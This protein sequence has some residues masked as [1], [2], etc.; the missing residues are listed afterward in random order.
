MKKLI[1]ILTTLAVLAFN[2]EVMAVW[3]NIDDGQ[4]HTIN[5]STYQEDVVF[6][7]YYNSNDPGTH[8]NLVSGGHVNLLHACDKSTISMTGGTIGHNLTANDNASITMS[9]GSVKVDL[10]ASDYSHIALTG[11]SVED[12]LYARYNSNITV[13][14]G[15]IRNAIYVGENASITMSGGLADRK[16]IVKDSGKV[17]LDGSDFSITDSDG[18]IFNLSK[19]DKLSE[20]A[21]LVE[22][23]PANNIRDY[24]SGTI[25]GTLAD[26]SAMNNIF[27]IYKTGDYAG[28][29]DIVIIPE[30]TTLLLFGFG[31][32]I[33]RKRR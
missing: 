5:D 20:Y 27:E 32:L 33:I 8:I 11:G 15:L 16:F 18:N 3:I 6:L 4:S 25:K 28:T 17:Y 24:Y 13:T 30:P 29:A 31:S 2:P 7:D 21:T 22:Y 1:A 23:R 26:G 19:G 9:G 12:N 14:G 10:Y